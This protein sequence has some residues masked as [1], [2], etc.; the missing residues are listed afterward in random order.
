MITSNSELAFN[1]HSLKQKLTVVSYKST[2]GLT[3]HNLSNF[4]EYEVRL[5]Q[6]W[7]ILIVLTKQYMCNLL[8]SS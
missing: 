2:V 6:S 8:Y 1:I 5:E 7:C 4:V 3:S